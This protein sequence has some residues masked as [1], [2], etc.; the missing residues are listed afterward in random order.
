M[1]SDERIYTYITLLAIGMC[2]GLCLMAGLDLL[3]NRQEPRT[4]GI[5][6]FGVIL[7]ILATIPLS[8]LAIINLLGDVPIHEFWSMVPP[9]SA[10]ELFPAIN[11]RTE[12]VRK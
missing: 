7:I 4:L 12:E 8:I 1:R 3:T 10:R 9:T 6:A 2:S 11:G 5:V